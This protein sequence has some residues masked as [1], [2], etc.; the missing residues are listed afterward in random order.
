MKT[1][2]VCT[3]KIDGEEKTVNYGELDVND[4]E[5]G[6]NEMLQIVFGAHVSGDPVMSCTIEYQSGLEMTFSLP[7]STIFALRNEN[8]PLKVSYA[9]A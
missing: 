7:Q 6:L 1:F 4:A 2:L 3:V 5:I 8:P 9:N